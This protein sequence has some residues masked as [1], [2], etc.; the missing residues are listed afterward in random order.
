MSRV[1]RVLGRAAEDL[2]LGYVVSKVRA[3]AGLSQADVAR[4]V[5]M[6]RSRLA[7]IE[8]AR[9]PAKLADLLAVEAAFVKIGALREGDLVLYT[10]RAL[11]LV[12]QLLLRRARGR[13]AS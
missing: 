4:L 8:S 5:P 10:R 9:Q 11:P 6:E 12:D 2:A 7:R 13:C 1:A 3:V